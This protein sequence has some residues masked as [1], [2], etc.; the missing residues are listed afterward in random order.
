ME[1][2]E[3]RGKKFNGDYLYLDI[4]NDIWRRDQSRNMDD[5][6]LTELGGN[7]IFLTK[8]NCFNNP[9]FIYIRENIE[10]THMI[11]ICGQDNCKNLY[12]VEHIPTK[13]K[14]GVGSSCINKFQPIN[15]DNIKRTNYCISC[16]KCLWYKTT[17]KNKRNAKKGLDNC[18]DCTYN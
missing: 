9:N 1:E 13:I 7:I 17:K 14:M 3:Y 11:C 10:N 12:I 4:D 16:N 15:Y 5:D 2:I 8:E 6:Y 18:L